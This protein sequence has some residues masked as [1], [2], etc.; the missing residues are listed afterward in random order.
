MTR[1]FFR[2]GML[3]LIGAVARLPAQ[4]SCGPAPAKAEP[5]VDPAKDLPRVAPT[6]PAAALSTWRVRPGFAL[7]LAAHEPQVRSPIAVAF[8]ERGRMFVCEMVDY[9]EQRDVVPHLG[10]VSR[11]EDRDGDGV[12]ET[13][14]LFADNLAWPT[15]LICAGGGVYVVATP[16]VWFFADTDDDGRA[17]RREVAFTGFGTGLKRLNVQ[18]LPNSA[19]WGLD[20]RIH[21]QTG[22]GN[23]G[24]I[25]CPTRPDLP[26]IEL[27]GKDFWFDPRTRD[28]G[29]DAGG[30]Q[31]GMNFD[32]WG[33][34][35]A[36][37]NSDHLQFFVYDDTLV[38]S[39]S[40]YALPA[41]R[42]SIAADGG[43]AEVFRISPD[44][45][46]RI[47]R[48][49]W[50][51]GGV[52]A[53]VVEGGGRVSGYF[54]G[55]TGTTVYRGDAFGPEFPFST[56][57]GDAGGQLVHRK[58]VTPD[59]VSFIGRR[60][61]DEAGVEFA[62]STDPW[63]RVV[64]F[65][66][67][68]DGALYLCDMYREVI[69]HPWS[70]PEAIKRHLDLTSGRERGRVYRI[71]PDKATW[72]P[73]TGLAL[74]RAGT[75]EWVALLSHPNGWHRDTASRL[76]YERQDLAAV[77]PLRALLRQK[78]GVPVARA[79]AIA[80]LEGLK[81]LDDTSL[82]AVARDPDP[83]VRERA[84]TAVLRRARIRPAASD[85]LPLSPE[86]AAAVAAC[87][88]DPNPRVRF[89]AALA[90]PLLE[91]SLRVRVLAQQASVDAADRWIGAALLHSADAGFFLALERD[92][93]ALPSAWVA[94]LL[95][96]LAASSPS[97][98]LRR[99]LRAAVIKG[100][101]RVSWL[102][103]LNEGLKRSGSALVSGPEDEAQFASLFQRATETALEVRRP[104][105]D[106]IESL[107][108][109]GLA[110]W[111]VAK[112]AAEACS[113][114]QV[115]DGVQAAAIELAGRFS[116]DEAGRLPLA[117]WSGLKPGARALALTQM[118]AR[119]ERCMLLLESLETGGVA[120]SDLGAAER[121]SLW[122]HP[123]APVAERARR[124]LAS[125]RPASRESVAAS[126]QP[127]LALTGRV[128]KGRE[129]YEQRCLVCHRAE[130]RGQAVGPDLVTVKSR[131]RDGL[132]TAIVDPHREV[133]PA[134]VAYTVSTREGATLV[135]LIS[136]DDA[137]GVALTLM[138]GTQ[139]T[140]ARAQIK[141]TA[142]EGKSL[143]PEGLEA[144]LSAQ[145][146]ADLL[147]FLEG[148]KG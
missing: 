100:R 83:G 68:P 25:T 44:E 75:G 38:S 143:M 142:S 127:A 145:A 135:G 14:T 53:G 70:I 19:T 45:P 80:A 16:D 81:S 118:L 108:V 40:A 96:T 115:T 50:R 113:G 91:P 87:A 39:D 55:A 4:P 107:G 82:A 28:F 24:V 133:A 59:G 65:A 95:E 27:A 128:E 74:D 35:F 78:G 5:Q 125:T 10:R 116:E 11:L 132:L 99:A 120:V 18:T 48:T 36:C 34:R 77:E 29:V 103:A 94:S 79:H 46:W 12:Y 1:L 121:E 123:S 139:V 31:Y 51:V 117:R 88:A 102:R 54:T 32:S 122:N 56:F 111:P 64:S 61:P 138:G 124:L 17:D 89:Y 41:P 148:L 126:F 129:L 136:R 47:V 112:R 7:Q 20:N 62:A 147:A 109:L 21:L 86:V 37:S 33:R 131:G 49:R 105:A 69:E 42:T 60:A 144:G 85:P 57:T 13:S 90:A 130:G 72:R 146:M 76:I 3:L 104:E 23:R 66:N 137:T 63:V 134:Y 97:A 71:V 8:D 15:G 101:P 2:L 140:L 52:V 92:L 93:E 26:G 30:A 67:A 110:P 22:G 9:S 141:G 84:L 6:E 114:N 106:R 98:D 58:I 73:R 119:P 43:A